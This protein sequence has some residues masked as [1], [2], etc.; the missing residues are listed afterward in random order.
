MPE[1]EPEP[2]PA[3]AEAVTAEP[4]P[5]PEGH[6]LYTHPGVRLSPHVSW[7]SPG[8]VG[9]LR[10]DFSDNLERWLDGRALKGVVDV[11]AGY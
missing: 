5:L 11:E 1:T 8:A 7:C 9:D 3:E 10:E 2:E 4:E 6:W